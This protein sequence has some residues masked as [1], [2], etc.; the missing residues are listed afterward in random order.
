MGLSIGHSF[1]SD[2]ALLWQL[3]QIASGGMSSSNIGPIIIG[4]ITELFVLIFTFGYEVATLLTKKH[5]SKLTGAFTAVCVL[6]LGWDGY[7][8]WTSG[9]GGPSDSGR[10]AFTIALAVGAVLLPIGALACFKLAASEG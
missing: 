2:L 8:N 7:T 3:W 5:N 6:A 4:W 9:Y 1:L 10:I